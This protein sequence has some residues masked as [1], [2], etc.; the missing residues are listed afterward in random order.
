[1][2]PHLHHAT[3]EG[4]NT[5]TVFFLCIINLYFSQNCSHLYITHLCNN[6]LA[7]MTIARLLSPKTATIS[8]GEDE[9]KSRCRWGQ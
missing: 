3:K 1:M 6:V 9:K 2:A 8:R 5:A 7:M 4:K